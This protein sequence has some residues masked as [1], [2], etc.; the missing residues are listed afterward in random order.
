MN[1]N[2][3]NLQQVAVSVAAA[4]LSSLLFIAAAVGP[5]GQII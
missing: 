1:V 5:A 2:V 3:A 4:L